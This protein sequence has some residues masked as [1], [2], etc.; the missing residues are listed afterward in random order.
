MTLTKQNVSPLIAMILS[1]CVYSRRIV[2]VDKLND[3]LSSLRD[4]SAWDARHYLRHA[5]TITWSKDSLHTLVVKEIIVLR[6]NHTT[7]E[8][9]DVRSASLS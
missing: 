8:Y 5:S 2:F 4:S 7:A 3:A 6:W 1:F 9:N